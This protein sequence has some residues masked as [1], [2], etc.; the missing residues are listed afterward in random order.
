MLQHKAVVMVSLLLM[1]LLN[2]WWC[3]V[4]I[5][6]NASHSHLITII[7]MIRLQL[8]SVWSD[9]LINKYVRLWRWLYIH[10]C[11]S[12]VHTPCDFTNGASLARHL[13]R[14]LTEL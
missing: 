6:C 8:C 11:W 13:A 5:E 2:T 3:L 4:V 12:Y 7:N 9:G 14:A 10:T 1:T